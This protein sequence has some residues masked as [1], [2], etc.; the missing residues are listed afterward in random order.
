MNARDVGTELLRSFVAVVEEASY[1]KAALRLGI[2]QPAVSS[3]VKKLSEH[4]GVEIF[5]KSTPGVKLTP[6]GETVLDH[7]HKILRQH[8]NL[9]RDV[10]RTASAVPRL[11]VGTSSVLVHSGVMQALA[12]FS[13]RYPEVDLQ[14][15]REMS[16]QQIV[17]LNAGDLDVSLAL[18][19]H[20]PR[21]EAFLYWHAPIVWLAAKDMAL[22]VKQPVRVVAHA[23]STQGAEEMLEVLRAAG[24]DYRLVL[25]TNDVDSSIQ[26]ARFGLGIGIAMMAK[27]P[28]DFMQVLGEGSGLPPMKSCWWGVYLNPDTRTPLT[29]EMGRLLAQFIA[30]EGAEVV[31]KK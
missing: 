19:W 30:H 3:H 15:H 11:R 16:T 9:L 20:A 5:D 8:D 2:S 29:E 17:M 25:K 22:P 18:T 4:L 13:R 10:E 31:E 1:T 14:F 24:I 28:P 21:E 6:R 12:E 26:A 7:A 23:A 27:S